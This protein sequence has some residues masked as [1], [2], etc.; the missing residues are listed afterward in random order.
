MFSRRTWHVIIALVVIVWII[1]AGGI[2]VAE[3][4][5]AEV[6][7]SRLI[8]CTNQNSHPRMATA[9]VTAIGC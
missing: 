4:H 3:A 5:G 1:A 7:I 8:L 9:S 2:G 6:Q